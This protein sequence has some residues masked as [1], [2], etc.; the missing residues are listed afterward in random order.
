MRHYP[1]NLQLWR[2]LTDSASEIRQFDFAIEIAN[3]G[4]RSAQSLETKQGLLKTKSITFKKAALSINKFDDF[5]MYK[6]RFFYLCEA[7][8]VDPRE[9]ANYLLLLQ[10]IGNE[11]EKPTIQLARQLGLSEPGDAVPIK[12]EWLRRAGVETKYTGFLNT[13]IGIQEFH[14]GNNEAGN[15][16]WTVAQQFAPTSRDFISSLFEFYVRSKRDKLNNF[17]TMITEFLKTYPEAARIRVLRGTYYFQEKKF[18]QA[19]DDY[20]YII[21]ANPSELIL[22]QRIK[23]CYQYMGQRSDAN[24]EQEIIET[25]LKRLTEEQQQ[26]VRQVLK[27]LDEQTTV[28]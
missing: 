14:L 24:D 10:F 27:R 7:V 21:D 6:K 15:L 1:D 11:N 22:H 19:I 2:L 17:E 5:E 18:Q 9:P 8:R 16:S 12:P 26:Q 23:T 20:R 25:K 13:M 28:E 3:L 4:L